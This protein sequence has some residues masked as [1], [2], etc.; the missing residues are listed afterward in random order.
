MPPAC[1]TSHTHR[2]FSPVPRVVGY[3]AALR[4]ED[5]E[6]YTWL[7]LPLADRRNV[8][9]F[10]DNPYPT[11]DEVSIFFLPSCLYLLIFIRLIAGFWMFVLEE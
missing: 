10:G 7:D 2:Q 5:P 1:N 3:N 6:A 9:P 11:L 4:I 8:V